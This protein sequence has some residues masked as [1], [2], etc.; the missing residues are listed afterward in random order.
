MRSPSSQAR[1]LSRVSTFEVFWAAIS[2]AVAYIVRDGWIDRTDAVAIY[3]GVAFV[4]FPE[5]RKKEL[6]S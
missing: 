3:C 2:P 6:S 5:I 1:L 4:I